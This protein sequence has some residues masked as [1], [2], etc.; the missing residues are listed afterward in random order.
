[1][2]P[3]QAAGHTLTALGCRWAVVGGD[4]VSARTV[5]RFTKDVDLSVSVATDA[6]AEAIV[7]E[8]HARGYRV[9]QLI[10]HE[11]SGRLST[12]RMKL[13][14]STAEDPD[15]GLLFASCG[16]EPEIVDAATP[17]EIEPGV[18]VPV[19]ISGHLIAMKL[20]AADADRRPQDLADLTALI[21]RAGDRDLRDARDAIQSIHARG[22]DRGRDLTGML[23]ARLR[24]A[25]PDP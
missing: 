21:E 2:N 17:L 19:A 20:L 6:E 25:R 16:I 9:A 22:F 11:P 5:P 1:M 14:G 7:R 4:A 24:S 23:D 10:E 15:L 12:V 8:L 3:I 13:P 18:V